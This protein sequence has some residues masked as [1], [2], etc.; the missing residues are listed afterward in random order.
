M[1]VFIASHP[2][3]GETIMIRQGE[4]G[5]I[6]YPC[7]DDAQKQMNEAHGNSASDLEAAVTCSMFGW[8]IQLGGRFK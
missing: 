3:N 4:S 1:R 6:P 7:S 5:Y 8:D 2:L